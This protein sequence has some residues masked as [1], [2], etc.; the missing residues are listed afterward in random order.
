[1]LNVFTTRYLRTREDFF[2]RQI[3]KVP[4]AAPESLQLEDP[5][6]HVVYNDGLRVMAT[7]DSLNARSVNRF[8]FMPTVFS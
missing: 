6:I 4:S 1:M 2:A 3:G 5:A 7:V 8:L